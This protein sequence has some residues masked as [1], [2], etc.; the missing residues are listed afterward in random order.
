MKLDF[1]GRQAELHV[2]DRL[3][4]SPKAEFLI[5]YGRRRVGKTALLS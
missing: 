3:W 1:H 5:V 4:A 2:L